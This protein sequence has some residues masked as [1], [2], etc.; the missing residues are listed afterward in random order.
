MSPFEVL[1][2]YKPL[3]IPAY[4]QGSTSIQALDATLTERDA[5]LRSLSN[6]LQHAQHRMSQQ[7]NAHHRDLQLEVGSLVLVRL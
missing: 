1:F 6:H 3:V 5:L 7:A 4:I 2:G